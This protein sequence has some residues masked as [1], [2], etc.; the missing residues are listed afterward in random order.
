MKGF[1]VKL[2]ILAVPVAWG[3]FVLSFGANLF[4]LPI[5]INFES[6][7][8]LGDSFGVLSAVM[9][10][11]AAYFTYSALQ[12]ARE[13]NKRLY[14]AENQRLE[15]DAVSRSEQTLFKLLELK[16]NIISQL[17][18]NDG[19]NFK[20]VMVFEKMLSNMHAIAERDGFEPDDLNGE[21][22]VMRLICGHYFKNILYIIEFIE[23]YLPDDGGRYLDLFR[24]Q[25]SGHEKLIL[26][27]WGARLEDGG[28]LKT[29]IEKNG[30]LAGIGHVETAIF[31]LKSV[32][33]ESSF[34]Y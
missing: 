32:Y 2:V 26:G 31:R 20:G 7:G 13:D 6:T 25:L 16:L 23:K 33:A 1:I 30:L 17:E 11:A 9:A 14:L 24:A 27:L 28:R 18:L 34:R 5:R 29:L 15:L 4:S 19:D 8:Q 12:E 3:A 21:Y 10:S 22:E